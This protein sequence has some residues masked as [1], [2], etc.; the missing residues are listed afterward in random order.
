M[1][2]LILLRMQA[3]NVV[4]LRPEGL[5]PPTYGSG[6]RRATSC[7]MASR[8]NFN[9]IT[10]IFRVRDLNPGRLGENQVS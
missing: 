5:E 7:A 10:N 2:S 6:I 4:F 9:C 1:A 8:F 3:L